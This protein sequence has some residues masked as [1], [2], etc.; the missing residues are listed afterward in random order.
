M[1]CSR[2][3]RCHAPGAG[4]PAQAR[5]VLDRARRAGGDAHPDWHGQHSPQSRMPAATTVPCC[6]WHGGICGWSLVGQCLCLLCAELAQC[7]EAV[8]NTWVV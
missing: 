8:F 5:P 3:G 4:R 2:A 6:V 7:M 1:A